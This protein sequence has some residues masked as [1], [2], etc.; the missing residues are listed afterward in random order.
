MKLKKNLRT[1]C[2]LTY[3]CLFDLAEDSLL[4]KGYNRR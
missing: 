1:F 3:A 2:T 4:Q